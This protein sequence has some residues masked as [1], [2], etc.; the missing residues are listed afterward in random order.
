[1]DKH[2]KTTAPNFVH[3]MGALR[4]HKRV[5]DDESAKSIRALLKQGV[6]R[7]AISMMY[8]LEYTD[9]KEFK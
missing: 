6:S 5:L 4:Q 9:L 3:G 2:V 8:S 7:K 1:M